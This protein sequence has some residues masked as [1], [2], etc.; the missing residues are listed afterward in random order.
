MGDA[1]AP[2][3]G[4]GGD[5]WTLIAFGLSSSRLPISTVS[6]PSANFALI[7]SPFAFGGSVNE[8]VNE[9]KERST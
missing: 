4:S 3:P 8:R 5:Q 1:A 9:P 6:T 7:S 2:E